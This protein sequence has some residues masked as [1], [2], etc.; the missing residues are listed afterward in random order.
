MIIGISGPMHVGKTA[1]AKAIVNEFMFVERAPLAQGVRDIATKLSLPHTRTNLQGIG[2]NMRQLDEDV[3]V[4]LWKKSHDFS[5]RNK[6]IDDVRYQNEVDLCDVHIRLTCK[7]SDQ[8]DRYQTSDKFDPTVAQS[9]WTAGT[10]HTTE[11]Q[12]LITP[13]NDTLLMDTHDWDA[14]GVAKAAIEFLSPRLQAKE[15]WLE[16]VYETVGG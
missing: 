5:S 6:V 13:T 11:N 9:D 12:A 1:I 15:P 10:F 4:N 8:W 16:S 3:W 7:P 14:D 2:H